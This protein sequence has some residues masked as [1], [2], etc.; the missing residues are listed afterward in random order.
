M[1]LQ[2]NIRFLTL[3][4]FIFK[5]GNFYERQKDYRISFNDFYF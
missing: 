4:F 3:R 5:L 2:N 1:Y